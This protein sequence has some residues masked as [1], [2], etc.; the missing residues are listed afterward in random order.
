MEADE[1][2]QLHHDYAMPLTGS[3]DAT[4]DTPFKR[5]LEESPQRLE[6]LSKRREAASW[7]SK[8]LARSLRSLQSLER[9][10]ALDNDDSFDFDDLDEDLRDSIHLTKQRFM[11]PHVISDNEDEPKD[12]VYH[13][14]QFFNPAPTKAEDVNTTAMNPL[15]SWKT[16]ASDFLPLAAILSTT[17]NNSSTPHLLRRKM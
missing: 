5:V 15:A 8:R 1:S 7:R 6:R 4:A 9:G 14:K 10:T 13:T 17:P 16:Q 3:D 12:S 11:S 2:T